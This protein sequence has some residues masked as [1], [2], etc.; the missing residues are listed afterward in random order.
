M[1]AGDQVR[2][3]DQSQAWKARG[4]TPEARGIVV[5][6]YRVPPRGDIRADVRFGVATVERGLDVDDLQTDRAASS[7]HAP[8]SLAS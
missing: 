8:S 7:R 6:L 3:R 5:D 2:F 4:L 1:R